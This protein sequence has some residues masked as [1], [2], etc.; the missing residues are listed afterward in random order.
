MITLPN[1][2]FKTQQGDINLAEIGTTATLVLYF[3]PKDSTP[4]CT[5]QANDFSTLQAE[6]KKINA[7]VV[8]V[9]RDSISSHFNFCSKQGINFP[10][11]SDS[12]ERLCQHFGVIKE[13]N[14]YGKTIMG[15]E[16]STFVFKNGSLVE[17]MR[18][19]KAAGH[20]AALLARLQ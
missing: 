14:M 19:V 16:R 11:I 12:D 6:F 17:E 20:A 9:S 2:P 10:L 4:G 1:T 5:V 3:Y 13:K 15:I 8:G 7:V 18:K